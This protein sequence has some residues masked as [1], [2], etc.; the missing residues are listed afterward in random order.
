[1]SSSRTLTI[2]RPQWAAGRRLDDGRIHRNWYPNGFAAGVNKLVN[3]NGRCSAL[4]FMCE[5][6]GNVGEEQLR[7]NFYP[8]QV[9]IG[10]DLE[11]EN[12]NPRVPASYPAVA[13]IARIND[14]AIGYEHYS[15]EEQERLIAEKLVEAFGKELGFDNV[16]FVD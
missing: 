9:G 3:P 8:F 1:M 10:L 6:F 11:S 5:Q 4:G 15:N 16:E 14:R 2:R 7:E 12:A 13:E